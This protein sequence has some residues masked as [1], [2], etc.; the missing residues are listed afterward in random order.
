MRTHLRD[1]T[2]LLKLLLKVKP[3]LGECYDWVEC[4]GCG[5]GW[6]IPHFESVG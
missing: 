5:A 6:Q 4:G 2:T 3:A 1:R